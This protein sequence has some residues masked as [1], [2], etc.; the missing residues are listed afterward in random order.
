[1][2]SVVASSQLG[3]IQSQSQQAT[4]GIAY[5]FEHPIFVKFFLIIGGIIVTVVMIGLAKILTNYLQKKIVSKFI[6][7]EGEHVER[8]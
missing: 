4:G 6:D 3:Q 8:A 2:E 7:Q 1:M 5:I